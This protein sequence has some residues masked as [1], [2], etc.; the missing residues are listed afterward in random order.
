MAL[1]ER[2]PK[3]PPSRQ[4]NTAALIRPRYCR[5]PW[6][7]RRNER[8]PAPKRWGSDCSLRWTRTINLPIV[9]VPQKRASSHPSPSYTRAATTS[10]RSTRPSSRVW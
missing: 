9:R 10:R 2:G 5:D 1:D 4:R 3:A 7:G 8:T 6:D